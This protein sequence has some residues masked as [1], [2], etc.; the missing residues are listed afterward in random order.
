MNT[1]VIIAS[2]AI[3]CVAVAGA[4]VVLSNGRAAF[5]KRQPV[6]EV[7][8]AQS[9]STSA[10]VMSQGVIVPT[11]S[12][13]VGLMPKLAG[14]VTQV[15]VDVGDRVAQGQVLAVV[16]PVESEGDLS[17]A[18]AAEQGARADLNLT[19]RPYRPEEI[20]EARLVVQ[21]D[22][23]TVASAKAHVA[24]LKSGYQP[25]E[26]AAANA[27]VD[28]AQATLDQANSELQRNQQL[29]DKELVAKAD[30]DISKTAAAVAKSNLAQAKAD[31]DLLTAGTRPELIQQAQAALRA[32]QADVKSDEAAYKV[33]LLGSRP[34]AIESAAAKVRKAQIDV[35]IQQRIV[36]RQFVRAPISGV[37]IDRNINV[38]ELTEPSWSSHTDSDHPMMLQR[39]T[40]FQI[41]DDSV[42]EFRANVDQRF[43]HSMHL[44]QTCSITVEPELGQTFTGKVVRMKPVINPDFNKTSSSAPDTPDLPLTFQI[45]VNVPNPDHR[46]VMGETGILNADQKTPGITIPQS[47]LNAF[48]SGKGVVFVEQ[49]GFV[50]AT[51]V[52]YADVSDGQVR[53]L[54]G[55]NEGDHVVV[56]SPYKLSDGMAVKTV[57]S[58]GT[59]ANPM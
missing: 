35:G 22:Y 50:K 38:G 16:S 4:V 47:A 44:G 18:Q 24:L 40:L 12:T 55:V 36:G 41:A 59:G 5:A 42:V 46:L 20:E 43:Y 19:M 28:S 56:S 11:I 3:G 52:R 33:K 39:S 45:W 58:D 30:F 6:V 14:Q 1:K 54:S 34:E 31:R 25:Q 48:A 57:S 7:A 21:R 17:L 15:N 53:I 8:V 32:A 49:G 13:N 29:L 27:K 51:A 10:S 23:E 37:V 26:I 2:V 9:G